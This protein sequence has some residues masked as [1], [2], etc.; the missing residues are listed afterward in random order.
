MRQTVFSILCVFVFAATAAKAQDA[1]TMDFGFVT[2]DPFLAPGEAPKRNDIT[3]LGGIGVTEAF[4]SALQ[5]WSVDYRK[6]YMLGVVA[7]RD[8]YDLGAGF[9]LGGVVGGAIRFGDDDP[10]TSGELWTGVRVRH[11]GLLIGNLLISPGVTA[12]VSVVS[13]V[14]SVERARELRFDGDATFLGYVG[15]ELAFRWRTL[16]QLEMVSQIHHRSGASGLFGDMGEGYNAFNWGL[17]YKF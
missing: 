1:S 8:F 13:D 3:V 12:G 4:G 11:Q 17:R 7:G 16:P 2:E 15:P 5:F 9:M 10:N 14:T 6:S